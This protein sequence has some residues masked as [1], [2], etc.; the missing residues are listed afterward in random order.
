MNRA[1]SQRVLAVLTG[2]AFLLA[3][4]QAGAQ[5]SP[6]KG[7]PG[8]QYSG[9]I[10]MHDTP[11]TVRPPAERVDTGKPLANDVL[12]ADAVSVE[13]RVSPPITPPARQPAQVKDKGKSR[14]WL[15]PSAM[16]TGQEE[17]EQESDFM[18]W[19]WLSDDMIETR[20]RQDKAAAEENAEQEEQEGLGPRRDNLPG[21]KKA[22]EPLVLDNTFSPVTTK[23]VSADRERKVQTSDSA[24]LKDNAT[25]QEK[26]IETRLAEQGRTETGFQPTVEDNRFGA[27]RMWGAER[28]GQPNDPAKNALPMTTALLKGSGQAEQKR[29]ASV[30]AALASLK[31]PLSA[32][33]SMPVSA[34]PVPAAAPPPSRLANPDSP[35]ALPRSSGLAPDYS[36]GGMAPQAGASSTRGFDAFQPIQPTQPTPAMKPLTDPWSR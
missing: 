23:R 15:V 13:P 2:M 16:K 22:G 34:A 20:A 6:A 21:K 17:P 28:A 29:D 14:N 7:S 19:G 33:I 32:P 26:T 27:D 24:V 1:R 30:A 9:Q 5:S 36:V 35:F 31:P 3:A 12:D 25:E 10:D 4:V 11:I 8:R 18:G